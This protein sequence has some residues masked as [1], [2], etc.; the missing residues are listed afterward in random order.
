MN[1]RIDKTG[2]HPRTFEVDLSPARIIACT[3]YNSV[4][5]RK[6]AKVPFAVERTEKFGI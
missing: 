1:M 3:D 6:V 2:N 4:A 5:H